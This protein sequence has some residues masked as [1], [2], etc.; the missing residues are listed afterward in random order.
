MLL[1]LVSV[2]SITLAR[3]H[4]AAIMIQSDNPL[5]TQAILDNFLRQLAKL[6]SGI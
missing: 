2:G 5:I 4:D 1:K 6:K 3:A